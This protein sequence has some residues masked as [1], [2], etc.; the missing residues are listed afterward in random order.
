MQGGT[1]EGDYAAAVATATNGLVTL[2]GC[3]EG[4]FSGTQT[5]FAFYEAA[6]VMLR[7]NASASPAI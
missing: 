7:A 5:G 4:L 3:T 1:T 6:S 2:A